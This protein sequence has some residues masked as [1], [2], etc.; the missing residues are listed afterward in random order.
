M[1]CRR[2]GQDGLESGGSS[3]RGRGGGG[4]MDAHGLPV[5]GMGEV[6]FPLN[7]LEVFDDLRASRAVLGE[8]GNSAKV[9]LTQ[10]RR[11]LGG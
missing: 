11:G 3:R 1:G 9:Q 7:L 10:T 4:G 5:R 6:F 8:R 2:G